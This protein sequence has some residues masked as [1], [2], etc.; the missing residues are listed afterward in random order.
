MIT[1]QKLILLALL[2]ATA[3]LDSIVAAD[4]ATPPATAPTAPEQ[5]T[6][7]PGSAVTTDAFAQLEWVQGEALKAWEPGKVYVFEC[8]ATW[9]GPCIAAIPHVNG[10][11]QKYQSKGLRVFGINVWEDGKEKVTNFV[12][13]KG[14]GMSYPV[15]YTG[16]GGAFETQWLNPAGV[17]GIPHAFVVRDGKL[18]FKTHPSFLS[19]GVIEALL[20]GEEGLPK[21]MGLLQEQSNQK[22]KY[23]AAT[24]SFAS[25]Q[26]ENDLDVMTARFA[27]MQKL[28]GEDPRLTGY[29]FQLALAKKDWSRA[30]VLLAAMP[31]GSIVHKQL[32][33]YGLEETPDAPEEMVKKVVAVFASVAPRISSPEDSKALA[34]LQWRLGDK[35]GAITSMKSAMEKAGGAKNA[36]MGVSPE[37]YQ[38]ILAAMEGGNFPDKPTMKAW[39]REA[40]EKHGKE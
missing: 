34:Q 28:G 23:K 16:R 27:E 32:A 1:V 25:A 10:L 37:P 15:A 2:A 21:A 13:G 17:R 18:L 12:K 11:H 6:L 3:G 30:E 29:E 39:F 14:E 33:A 4:V 9:C 24:R 19:D 31:E 5:P 26:R 22:A 20:A 35:K 8:W 7:V 40:A 36:Q 38:K